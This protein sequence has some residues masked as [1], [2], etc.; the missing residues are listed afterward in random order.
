[1]AIFRQGKRVGPFDIRIGL[2]RGREYENLNKPKP[3][4]LD[5]AINRFRAGIS[6]NGG[7]AKP[8]K[9][10]VRF[11]LPASLEKL[12]SSTSNLPDLKQS[13]DQS[14]FEGGPPSV[15]QSG[16]R[17][18]QNYTVQQAMGQDITMMCQK[19]TMPERTFNASPF[20]T[21]YGPVTQYPTGVQYGSITATFYADKFLRQRSYFELWQSAMYDH[22]TNNFNFYDEYVT[23]LDIFQL[24][25]YESKND[26]SH[27]TYGVRLFE[28]YPVI[29]GAVNYDYAALDQIQTFDVT[30]NFRL[31]LN[32]AVDVDASGKVAGLTTGE[33]SRQ[34][35]FL[36]SLPPSLRTAARDAIGSI[37]RSI[38]IGRVTGGKLFPP[39]V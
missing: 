33:I 16:S 8:S 23:P 28:A 37:K 38:P 22:V 4:S 39:F 13:G 5:T 15:T 36:A 21:R 2:P 26:T 35:G 34:G 1:M 32:F 11:Q 31:W 24:G 30:F 25:E 10:S 29:I 14:V 19:I 12:S 7:L 6:K 27:I 18:R 20:R 3:E 17:A 9:F